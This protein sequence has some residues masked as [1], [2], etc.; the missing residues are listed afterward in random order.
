[1]KDKQTPNWLNK[2]ASQQ[3]ISEKRV[4][5]FLYH[6]NSL[7]RFIQQ[8]CS[9][10][11]NLELISEEWQQPIRNEADLLSLTD[12]DT[13]FIRKV[14]LKDDEQLL[15]YARSIIP[16]KTLSGNNKRLLEMGKQ[17]L[18]DF[19]F[20]DDSTYRD[21]MRYAIIPVD[22]ELHAEATNGSDVTSELWGR[23]SL[24]YIEQKPLL[25]TEIFLPAILECNKN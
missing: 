4:Y 19:L 23:Q 13:A 7:T 17:P 14:F 22:C 1:M 20:N 16:E 5:P 2:E 18:G 8:H 24:F 11:F 25:V 6:E 10:L 3:T 21:V 12:N 9:G 15:V